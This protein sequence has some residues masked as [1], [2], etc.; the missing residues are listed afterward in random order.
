VRTLARYYGPGYER[1]PIVDILAVARFLRH[2]WHG[3]T[4]YYGSDGGGPVSVLDNDRED[5]L[6]GHLFSAAGRAYYR[7]ASSV[8]AV[9]EHDGIPLNFNMWGGGDSGASCPACRRH[10]V[11][12]KNGTIIATKAD[13]KTPAD[14]NAAWVDVPKVE[15][16][17][18][19][20]KAAQQASEED[21]RQAPAEIEAL[22]ASAS[23]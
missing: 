21:P 5:A 16:P 10:W 9:C 2:V 19:R 22:I 3:C 23:K 14:S 18:W 12:K 11:Y 8:D 1:G 20:L 17:L 6:W 7:H 15:I 4:V 13:Y